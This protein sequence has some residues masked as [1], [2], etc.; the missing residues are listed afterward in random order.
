[1]LPL[2]I[3][4]EVK[5]FAIDVD[6]PPRSAFMFAIVPN[7]SVLVLKVMYSKSSDLEMYSTKTIWIIPVESIAADIEP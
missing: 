4:I 7:W 1:M 5:R 6:S 2:S 3:A